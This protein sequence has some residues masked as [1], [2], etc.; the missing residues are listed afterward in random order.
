MNVIKGV[1]SAR[2]RVSPSQLPAF[3]NFINDSLLDGAV[4]ALER[5][6]QVPSENITTVWG[7]G[8]YELPL[9]VKTLAD[10]GKI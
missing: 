3:N 5:I 4:D 7:A 1:V 9:A 8:A 6:G 2:V 10:T